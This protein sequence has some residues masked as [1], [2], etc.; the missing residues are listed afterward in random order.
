MKTCKVIGCNN[1]VWGRGFCQA[2]SPRTPLKKVPFKKVYAPRSKKEVEH[3]I[4]LGL[5]QYKLMTSIMQMEVYRQNKNSFFSRIWRTRPHF[6]EHCGC[7]L[8]YNARSYMFDHILEKNK[9]PMLSLEEENI[10][11]VCLECH[12]NKTRGIISEKYQEKINFV[13]TK[14]DVL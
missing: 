12:D 11:L 14:F 8:G 7:S 3:T 9:Y 1:P 6:C 5:E 10:W 4:Y 13:R 2:H